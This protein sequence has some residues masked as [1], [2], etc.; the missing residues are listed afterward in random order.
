LD[1]NKTVLLYDL[2]KTFEKLSLSTRNKYIPPKVS[3][4]QLLAQRYF[5]GYGQEYGGIAV[6]LINNA[7]TPLDI[8]YFEMVPWFLRL[9]FH[10]LD[11]QINGTKV[12][13]LEKFSSYQMIPAEA[14]STPGIIEFTLTLPPQSVTSFT[15]QF[16][17]AF[18]HWT[19]HPPDAH[20]G[21][22]IGSAVITAHFPSA[23]EDLVFNGLEWS[24]VVYNKS[25][26]Q[27]SE[28]KTSFRIYTEGLLVSLPTP[29]FSM[30]YNV[31]TLT[32]TVFALF[33]GS[34]FTT[35]VKKLKA[36]DKTP[37]DFVSNR[38]ILKLIRWLLSFVDG[39]R[40]N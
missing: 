26:T 25:S 20:R 30:P 1:S 18:L 13:P 12:D 8:T 21:F 33:F 14:K 17:K 23:H 15:I 2:K 34:L 32:G 38:P 22:D 31:I 24:S 19:E 7:D 37:D 36:G 6:H 11:L 3:P 5:T 9:Y 35:L 4:P 16:E 39:S 40:N 29:D 27:N 10:T 28:E